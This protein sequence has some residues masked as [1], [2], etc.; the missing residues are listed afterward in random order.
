MK[1]REEKRTEE[2]SITHCIQLKELQKF[3]NKNNLNIER[4]YIHVYFFFRLRVVRLKILHK[5]EKL[6]GQFHSI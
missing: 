2:K 6:Q 1:R 5:R 3:W 4:S